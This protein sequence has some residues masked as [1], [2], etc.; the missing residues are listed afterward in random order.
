[1]GGE[2]AGAAALPEK[3]RPVLAAAIHLGC[4]A[5]VTGDRSH[6]G[7]LFGRSIRGVAI[8][9]PRSIAEKLLR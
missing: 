1:M 5:L 2:I 8:H 9:S 3:N 6:F 4:E 7:P